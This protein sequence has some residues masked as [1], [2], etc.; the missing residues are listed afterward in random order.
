[1]DHGP[2]LGGPRATEDRLRDAGTLEISWLCWSI[3][4]R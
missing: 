3:S 2:G 4:N 1:M